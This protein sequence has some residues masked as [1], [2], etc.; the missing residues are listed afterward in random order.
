MGEMMKTI[1][2]IFVVTMC[3]AIIGQS[4]LQAHEIQK[5]F[6]GQCLRKKI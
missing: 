4:F 5:S 6:D 3:L 2:Q 1:I